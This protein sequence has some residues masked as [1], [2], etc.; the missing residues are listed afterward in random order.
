M[1]YNGAN[2]ANTNL[3]YLMDPKRARLAPYTQSPGIYLCPAD[4]S[5][6][7]ISGKRVPRV[8]STELSQAVGTDRNG[9]PTEAHWLPFARYRVYAKFSD[10]NVPG[11][12]NTWVFLD[13]NPDSINCGFGVEMPQ[14]PQ[15]TRMIDFPGWNHNGAGAFS[16]GDGHAEI[17]RWVDAR[18]KAPM[19]YVRQ[20]QYVQSQPNNMDIL[21]LSERTS[22]L[23]EGM[24]P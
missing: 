20:V 13:E 15:S 19:T 22:A 7:T 14:T 3:E 21:W 16:F 10:M 1:D 11:P 17:R 2:P 18:T 24:T 12:S 8:R 23:R 5:Y 4:R 9:R 6:V